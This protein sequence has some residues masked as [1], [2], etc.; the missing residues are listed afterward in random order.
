MSDYYELLGV[1]K[2]ADGEE[3]KKAYR[4]L[5]LKYHPDRNSGSKDSEERFKEV[6]E[7]Y[8]V[9]KDPQKRGRYD[10]YGEAGVKSGTGGFQGGFDF[11]D[12]LEIFMRDFGGMGGLEDLFGRHGQ[13]RRG[14]GPERGENLRVRL[15]MTLEEV[16]TGI[17]R[18][19]RLATLEP[20]EPCE[21]SGAAEGTA[22]TTCPTCGGSGEIRHVQ[23]SV[24]GQFMSVRPCSTCL[25]QRTVIQT[26]C[27]VC[28]SEGRVRVD[29]DVEVE[30]P[31]G[32]SSDNFLTLRGKGNAGSRGGPRGDVVVLIEVA[33]DPYFARDGANIT[34]ERPI[35]FSQAA[36]G[37]EI[38][39][40]TVTGTARLSVPGG[41]QSGQVLRLRGEGLPEL[42]GRGKGD[43]FVRII[44][45]IPDELSGE[46]ERAI[47]AL[48]EVED[49]A[50]ERIDPRSQKGFW[51]RVKDAFT[52]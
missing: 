45:W 4:K 46:Q 32:V 10:Q 31:P 39:V 40:P 8:E 37:D 29:Q 21:G 24:F 22:A 12:A 16:A 36:L 26:P 11:S 49:E 5:A 14:G 35:T 48:G 7:A 44:V 13:G 33:E 52:L 34:I 20:C 50:P 25:G 38:E 43:Q 30:V 28:H 42:E 9:L 1:Q 19:I 17:R 51:S 2:G 41:T 23:H 15:P 6:T 47:R 18:R 27:P 3:I